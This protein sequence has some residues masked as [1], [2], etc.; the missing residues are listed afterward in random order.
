MVKQSPPPPQ[1]LRFALKHF[2]PMT[3]SVTVLIL[4]MASSPVIIK[5]CNTS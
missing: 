5:P 3:M 2:N 4:T 1:K